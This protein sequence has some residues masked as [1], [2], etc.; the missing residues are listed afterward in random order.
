MTANKVMRCFDWRWAIA[1]CLYMGI[2]ALISVSAY[3]S[4]IPAQIT[5]IPLYDTIG[6]FIL[7]GIAGYLS[8]QTLSQHRFR[9]GSWAIPTGPLLI[10]ILVV[11][12]E[13]LQSLSPARTASLSDLISNW[14]GIIFFLWLGH[15]LQRWYGQLKQR[16][17]RP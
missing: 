13:M 17:A 14:L 15:R 12:D 3:A 8:H 7:F 6:H 9:V 11:C 10:A 16:N 4:R 2:L 1:F 5:Q